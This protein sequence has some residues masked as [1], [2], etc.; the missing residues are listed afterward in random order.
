MSWVRSRGR[1]GPLPL[2]REPD[3]GIDP[4][5]QDYD[6]SLRQTLSPLSHPGVPT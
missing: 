4:E 6:L 1:S 5:L 2:S 3:V